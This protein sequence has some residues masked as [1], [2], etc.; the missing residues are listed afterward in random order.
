PA[1]FGGRAVTYYGRRSFK[2]EEAIRHGAAGVLIVH[3]DET[4]GYP[5]SVVRNSWG[6]RN[7]YVKLAPGEAALALA[8]WTTGEAGERILQQSAATQGMSLNELLAIANTKD[9]RAIPLNAKIQAHL[10][11]EVEDFETRNV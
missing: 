3:T 8:G 6:G 2:Y 5:W 4:A 9:F 11:S 1:F 10:I 7:P